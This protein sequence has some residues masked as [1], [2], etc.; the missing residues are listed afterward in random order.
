MGPIHDTIRAKA[1]MEKL[2]LKPD[3]VDVLR[4]L[5]TEQLVA[6]LKM[7]DPLE[8]KGSILFWSVMDGGSVAVTPSAHALTI[9]ASGTGLEAPIGR[10]TLEVTFDAVPVGSDTVPCAPRP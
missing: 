1:F 8:R 2:G 7:P 10:M 3:Q 5:P 9:H 6:A 4:K